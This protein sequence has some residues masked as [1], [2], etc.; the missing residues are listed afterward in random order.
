MP[1]LMYMT[2]YQNMEKRDAVW[3]SFFGSKK[4]GE[5]STDPEY[6]NNVNKADKLLLYPTEYSDY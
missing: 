2:T 4:W 1:N 5:L 6:L 3:E